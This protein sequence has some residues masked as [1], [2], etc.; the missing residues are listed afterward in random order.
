MAKKRVT[1]NLDKDTPDSYRGSH[2]QKGTPKSSIL[3]KLEFQEKKTQSRRSGLDN[4][5][6]M[7]VEE[8]QEKSQ[9]FESENIDSASM[10]EMIYATNNDIADIIEFY[11]LRPHLSLDPNHSGKPIFNNRCSKKH[12]LYNPLVIKRDRIILNSN[13]AL[14]FT[15]PVGNNPAVR[16]KKFKI[17]KQSQSYLNSF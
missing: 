9:S 2:M 17:S 6:M 1:I 16:L 7:P 12:Q 14:S 10:D 13:Q 5:E 8:D 15:N 4:L 11:S 3:R